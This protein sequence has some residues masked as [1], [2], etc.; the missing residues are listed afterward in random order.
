MALQCKLSEL[1]RVVRCIEI[2]AWKCQV[3]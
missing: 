3:L 1:I 2:K